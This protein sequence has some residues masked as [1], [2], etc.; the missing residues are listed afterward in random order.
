ML[1][2]DFYGLSSNEDQHTEN[3]FLNAGCKKVLGKP[4]NVKKIRELFS[5]FEDN[6]K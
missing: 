4:L 3:L 1:D 5:G 6:H 2:I